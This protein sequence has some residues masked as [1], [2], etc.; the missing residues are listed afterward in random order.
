[1]SFIFHRA[2]LAANLFLENHFS[3]SKKRG[4]SGKQNNL[5]DLTESGAT[6]SQSRA[7][8]GSLTGN[9]SLVAGNA[10]SIHGSDVFSGQ[11]ATLAGQ[12]ID[13]TAGVDVHESHLTQSSKR[14][15]SMPILDN[16]HKS[17][18]DTLDVT[19]SG[20]S[21]SVGGQIDLAAG[22]R[23]VL[24]GA[25][26][27][28]TTVKVTSLA[29]EGTS[30]DLIIT[31][32]LGQQQYSHTENSET[33]HVW[34]KASGHGSSSQ[35]FEQTTINGQLDIDP[36][37]KIHVQTA[38]PNGAANVETLSATLQALA[39]SDPG[40]GYLQDLAQNPNVDWQA[41]TLAQ[42]QWDYSQSGLTPVGAAI[43][44][45]A[46]TVLTAGAGSAA[47]AT[48]STTAAT[49]TAAGAAGT[50]TTASVVGIEL[51]TAVTVGGVTT[52]TYTAAG[53]AL[54]AG[55]SAILASASVSLVNNHGNLKET[56]KEL[57]SK[58]SLKNILISMTTAGVVSGMNT[59]FFGE[60]S[61]FLTG[62]TGPNANAIINNQV[63]N[64]FANNVIKNM[65]TNLVSTGIN[66][67]INGNGLNRDSLANALTNAFITAGLAQGAN[68]IGDGLTGGQLNAFTHQ[69][70]HAM[71]GCAGGVATSGNSDGCAP[72]AVGALVGELAAK[73]ATETLG[74]D[75]EKALN[76]AKVMSAASGLIVVKDGND[77]GAVN[78]ANT[79]GEC[80]GE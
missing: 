1:M 45:I 42:D 65:A 43:L 3:E 53:A 13:I 79:M 21:I 77:A 48:T 39:T 72:G 55:M 34:Q 24:E 75:K 61:A 12:T 30:P 46:V 25:H 67:T 58:D 33:G 51:S 23:I 57:G 16:K 38:T 35:T 26:L 10:L 71:L 68:S 7:L 70:A 73:Y 62:Q 63:A 69:L 66:S 54:N 5:S 56:L 11:N 40:L 60:G 19:R 27:D 41:V 50:A 18:D 32:S 49:T 28:A 80:G 47:A 20:S 52:V 9:V 78:L 2:K 31:G 44:V 6:Q 8:V 59:A 14:S 64:Q 15:T 4:I 17:Q 37:F 29:P 76:F 22:Q 74:W 36:K